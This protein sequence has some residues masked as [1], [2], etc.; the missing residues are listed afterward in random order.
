MKIDGI[1]GEILAVG[2][3]ID[4]TLYRAWRL[5]ILMLMHF[6]RY[7]QF[8]LKYGLVRRKMHKLCFSECPS[9]DSGKGSRF[10]QEQAR[11]MAHKIGFGCTPEKAAAR[12]DRIAYNGLAPFFKRIPLCAGV[13]D[14]F[15]MLKAQGVKIALLS[16]FPPQ[17]KGDLWGL[18]KYVD[19]MLGTED[20]GALKPNPAPFM[21]MAAALG[22]PCE[23]ILYVGNN[24]E[25]DVR[26]AKACGMKTAHFVSRGQWLF[27]YIFSHN[28]N[29]KDADFSFDTYS[30]FLGRIAH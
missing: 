2:F 19:V 15:A 30:K 11:L 20:V 3:D 23:N 14:V 7:S 29:V 12:L 28:I 21:A 16:D 26:G 4:G 24:A 13:D 1:D 18:K 8:F 17:Q 27:R 5:N 9:L 25:Y 22:V 6:L 10:W